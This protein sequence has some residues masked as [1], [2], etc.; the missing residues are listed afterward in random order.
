[1]GEKQGI[2]NRYQA[3][4]HI[5]DCPFSLNF[6]FYEHLFILSMQGRALWIPSVLQYIQHTQTWR[7]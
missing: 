6:I 7:T 3:S 4:D 5:F 1:M 2:T